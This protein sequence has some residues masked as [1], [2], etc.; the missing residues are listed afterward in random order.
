MVFF[1]VKKLVFPGEF[2]GIGEEY[3]PGK[4]AFENGNGDIHAASVGEAEFDDQQKVVNVNSISRESVPIDA[5]SVVFGRVGLVTDSKVFVDIFRAEHG[6]KQ[7]IFSGPSAVIMVFNVMNGYVESLEEMF[8]IGDL[9]KAKAMA[10]SPYTI[11]LE[12]KSDESLGIIKGFCAEC[13]EPVRKFDN[14]FKCSNCAQPTN[15]KFSSD[16]LVLH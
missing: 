9:V 8:K 12:T 14:G 11:E 5:G 15:R 2:L 6:G 4:N 1:L 7:R 10:V 16:Y 3:L 13:R